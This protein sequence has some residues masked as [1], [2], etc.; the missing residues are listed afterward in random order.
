M[1]QYREM[2]SKYMFVGMRICLT[3]MPKTE[4]QMKSKSDMFGYIFQ[5]TLYIV[6]WLNRNYRLS[7]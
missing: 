7:I 1:A 3:K 2:Y 5:D 4:Y 6:I